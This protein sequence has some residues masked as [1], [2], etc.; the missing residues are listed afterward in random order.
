MSSKDAKAFDK[1]RR[2]NAQA[3]EHARISNVMQRDLAQ[4]NSA[5]AVAARQRE[6]LAAARLARERQAFLDTEVLRIQ[7]ALD[8]FADRV[9]KLRTRDN[10]DAANCGDVDVT[11]K[12][13]PGGSGDDAVLYNPSFNAQNRFRVTMV[14]VN[15]RLTG[16]RFDHSVS[17]RAKYVS[18][19]A[20]PIFVHV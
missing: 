14:E 12:V 9:R 5:E 15:A 7:K 16:F 10:N 3:A 4:R 20:T 19:D 1:L 8:G 13:I 17:A 18:T 2:Q 11:G 6:A